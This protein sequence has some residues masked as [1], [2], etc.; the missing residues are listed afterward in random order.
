[1]VSTTFVS[2]V[3]IIPARE[4]EASVAWYRDMLAFEVVHTEHEYGIVERDDM[5]IHFWGQAASQRRT[6]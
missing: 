2:A 4:I 3:P 1:M 6:R 5:Q